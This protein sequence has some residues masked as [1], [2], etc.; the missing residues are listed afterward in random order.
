MNQADQSARIER[1]S[2]K[3]PVIVNFDLSGWS[4]SKWGTVY[5]KNIQ[6]TMDGIKNLWTARGAIPA[7]TF[8]WGNPLDTVG[9]YDATKDS[10]DVGKIVTP[11]TPENDSMMADLKRHADYVQQLADADIPILFRP[12]HEIDGGWF[13]WTDCA[14]PENT[15]KLYRIIYD[16]FVNVRHF[17]NLIWNF[18]AGVRTCYDKSSTNAASRALYYPGD[19][20]ADFIGIDIYPGAVWG[21]PVVDTY[22]PAFTTIGG[23]TTGKPITLHECAGFPNPDSLRV[24]GPRWLYALPWWVLHAEYD[25]A[26]VVKC[27]QSAEY[28][29]LDEIP[30]LRLPTANRHRLS[31]TADAV[32]SPAGECQVVDIKGRMLSQGVSLRTQ[33]RLNPSVII[34]FSTK[35]AMRRSVTGR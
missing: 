30:D 1:M 34:L 27:A 24:N 18:N 8:H 25:S 2:G 3:Y 15:A 32:P 10:V 14:T 21:S 28:T 7:L 35:A 31:Q 17:N 4:Q 12:L 11:G 13:W 9:T 22:E 19:A 6:A 33:S 23:I 5:R 29:T 16:Y 20:F 26:Y